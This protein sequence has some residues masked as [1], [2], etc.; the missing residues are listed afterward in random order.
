MFGVADEVE[1]F[2]P[3]VVAEGVGN[4]VQKEQNRR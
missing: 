1:Q 3:L 4:D 2:L